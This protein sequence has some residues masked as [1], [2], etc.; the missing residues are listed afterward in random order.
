MLISWAV[1]SRCDTC[2][3]RRGRRGEV[4]VSSAT[5]SA[6][7]GRARRRRRGLDP[8]Q[9]LGRFVAGIRR[10]WPRLRAAAAR[11]WSS[12]NAFCRSASS[13]ARSWSLVPI[14]DSCGGHAGGPIAAGAPVGP[15]PGHAET[16]GDRRGDCAVSVYGGLIGA[17]TAGLGRWLIAVPGRGV[18]LSHFTALNRQGPGAT[19]SLVTR[20]CSRSRHL[21]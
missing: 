11:S 12:P 19:L 14:A 17:R 10:P 4:T 15:P 2:G 18:L 7:S 1:W 9:D 20:S 16:A 6:S 5:R 13:A 21:Q 8:G 3:S